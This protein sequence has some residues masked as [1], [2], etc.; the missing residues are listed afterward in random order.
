MIKNRDHVQI[1]V[2]GSGIAG[3]TC[4]LTLARQGYD[5]LVL[6]RDAELSDVVHGRGE[7]QILRP[8]RRHPDLLGQDRAIAAD[9]FQMIAGVHVLVLGRGRQADQPAPHR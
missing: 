4:A 3:L 5:V 7:L 9:A 1:L 2:I 6:S 8:L